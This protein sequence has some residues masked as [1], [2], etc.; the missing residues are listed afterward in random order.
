[1]T[2]YVK[3]LTFGEMEASLDINLES[4]L[5]QMALQTFR[6]STNEIKT[7]ISGKGDSKKHFHNRSELYDSFIPD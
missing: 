2:E 3:S 6:S 1:M 7:Q 4:N 5:K